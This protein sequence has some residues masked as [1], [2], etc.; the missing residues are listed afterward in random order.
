LTWVDEPVT[1]GQLLRKIDALLPTILFILV[2]YALYALVML[3][4]RWQSFRFLGSRTRARPRWLTLVGGAGVL[5]LILWLIFWLAPK[6][7]DHKVRLA[8][9]LGVSEGEAWLVKKAAAL[10]V[11][12]PLNQ[13]P[14]NG[15]PAYALLHPESPPSLLPPAKPP[16][17][18]KLRK[19]KG[20]RTSARRKPRKSRA[21]PRL[22]KKKRAR[23]KVKA[24]KKK[25]S[26]SPARL[27][28]NSRGSNG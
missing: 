13:K 25:R 22:T 16:A 1:L 27:T 5:G 10:T 26:G 28:K 18:T 11:P 14:P 2:A 23:S 3:W 7:P 21:K 17:G 19:R 8:G 15:E 4:C 9:I 20:K 24:Q 6:T 12:P